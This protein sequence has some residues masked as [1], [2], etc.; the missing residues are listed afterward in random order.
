MRC[1]IERKAV[2]T[3][4]LL[5]VNTP[6]L[7]TISPQPGPPGFQAIYEEHS[8]A[9]YYF[10]LRFVGD[11]ARAEDIV[12]DVFVKV[13][14]KLPDFRGDA[15][16]RTWLYR[17]AINHC[18]NAARTWHQRHVFSNAEEAVWE[19]ATC[20]QADPLRNLET[21]ELGERIRKTLQE[22]SE[23]YRVILLLAADESLSYEQIATLTEQSADAVRGKLY[24]ARKAFIARFSRT[25]G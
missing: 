24:R 5:S 6:A 13:F 16:I 8:K 17:I 2:R 21:K 4:L 18:H 9:V 19:G 22:L 14:S 1:L 15:N 20:G 25:S 12:H 23:E 3:A 7:K 11:P 10:V